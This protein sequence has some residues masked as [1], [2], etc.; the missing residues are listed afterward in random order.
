[1]L[2]RNSVQIGKHHVQKFGGCGQFLLEK[3]NCFSWK[4]LETQ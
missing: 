2:G 1:M 3:G 4:L